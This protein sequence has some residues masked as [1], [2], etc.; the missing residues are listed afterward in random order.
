MSETESVP[1]TDGSVPQPVRI[2]SP[3]YWP[4]VLALSVCFGLWGILTSPLLSWVGLG[5]FLL[6]AAHWAAEAYRESDQGDE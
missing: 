4:F 5:G 3:T 1:S 6:S 2:P